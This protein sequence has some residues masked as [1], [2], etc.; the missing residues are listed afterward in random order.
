MSVKASG[1]EPGQ[2]HLNGPQ[3]TG[4]DYRS[5]SKVEFDIKR[6]N[7][8]A[9]SMR[10]G[11]KLLS[12]LFQPDVG[13]RFPALLSVSPYPRQ[14]Q[15]FGVPLGLLEAGASDFF[16][17]RVPAGQARDKCSPMPPGPSLLRRDIPLPIAEF[18]I[19]QLPRTSRVDFHSR[20]ECRHLLGRA[21]REFRRVRGL[22]PAFSRRGLPSPPS[23]L[24]SRRV[25]PGRFRGTPTTALLLDTNK[26]TK[27]REI[28]RNSLKTEKSHSFYSIQTVALS[29]ARRTPIP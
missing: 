29:V 27:R 2:R 5:L 24:T 8:V 23:A 7:D 11:T 14:I 17:P 16:V 15:D 13:G 19:L 22:V 3:T 18:S 6:T 25:C 28:R 21:S 20:Y 9:I 12:D 4:R 26:R 1:V 10:D